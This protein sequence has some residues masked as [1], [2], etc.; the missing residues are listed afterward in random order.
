MV[1]E[2]TYKAKY[3]LDKKLTELVVKVE[4]KEREG[5]LVPG[6][7]IYY[8]VTTVNGSPYGDEINGCVNAQYCAESIGIKLLNEYKEKAKVEGKSFRIKRK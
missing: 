1:I 4:I 8:G 5:L 7:S 2:G 6:Q 3:T